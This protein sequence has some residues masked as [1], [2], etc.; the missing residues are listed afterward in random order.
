[1]ACPHRGRPR[2][3]ELADIV[4]RFGPEI[5]A[6]SALTGEQRAAL[7]AI[8]R[9]RTPILGGHVE[10]C[11]A[12]G[13][14]RTVFRSCRNRH[15]PKC[16]TLNRVRWIDARV[17]ELLPVDYFHVV[18]TLPDR[19][20]AL[21]LRRPRVVYDILLRA[22]IH[23]LL[24]FAR[25]PRHLGAEPAIVAVLHTWGQQLTLHPH[26][27][28]I[29]TAGGLD[30][31]RRRWLKTPPGFLFPVRALSRVFRGKVLD[32]L[33]A[34]A[35]KDTVFDLRDLRSALTEH[36]WVVY[37]KKPFAGPRTL[38]DYLARYTHRV[39]LTNDRLLDGGG[40]HVRLRWRDYARSGKRRVLT[41][42]GATLLRRFLLHVL[43]H[44]F[45]HV[46]HAGL[47]AN[48]HKTAKLR[49]C[50][51]YFGLQSRATSP[52]PRAAATHLLLRRLGMDPTRCDRCGARAITTRPLLDPAAPTRGPTRP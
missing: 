15:C 13:H 6:T 17:A 22:A 46:R 26:V 23:T 5:E 14:R 37:A 44:G 38:V 51:R 7:R 24:T 18:F 48:R 47:L 31:T 45:H 40:D 41:I 30:P 16:Q 19:L 33:A 11:T 43:P 29:V 49:A 52:P 12:C 39:A 28:C 1:M 36:E 27:H 42:H 4:R 3:V 35:K 8:A 25:D 21:A 20:H 9:C 2:R 34:S 32:R 10:V 50:D